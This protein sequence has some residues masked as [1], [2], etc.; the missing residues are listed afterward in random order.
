MRVTT[1]RGPLAL[2]TGRLHRDRRTSLGVRIRFR[3]RRWRLDR[4]FDRHR[5]ILRHDVNWVG[6]QHPVF[7]V[8]VVADAIWRDRLA[9]GC[10]VGSRFFPLF[11][12][13]DCFLRWCRFHRLF[14][15]WFW[16]RL[17][18]L[19]LHLL[20]APLPRWLLAFRNLDH[21]R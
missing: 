5:D 20:L 18:L 1:C 9:I 4:S 19:V 2:R 10:V 6:V 14:A 11:S 16:S 17:L 15:A 8:A 12:R 3:W 21:P 7:P 13:R